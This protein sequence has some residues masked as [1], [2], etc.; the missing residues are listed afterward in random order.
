MKIL[1]SL[2][3]L[4][5]PTAAMA[6]EQKSRKACDAADSFRICRTIPEER[7]DVSA[8]RRVAQA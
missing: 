3:L 2:L 7:R 5:A 1:L 6:Q 8:G 4:L